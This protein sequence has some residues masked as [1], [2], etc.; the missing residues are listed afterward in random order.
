LF[1][2]RKESDTFG[3]LDVPSD[4]YYGANTAR[5]LTYFDIGGSRELMPVSIACDLLTFLFQ[6]C[7]QRYCAHIVDKQLASLHLQSTFDN[8]ACQSHG[9]VSL[10]WLLLQLYVDYCG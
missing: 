1:Q 8:F 4:K 6:F 5:A 9:A 3:E 10:L 7:R 2:Y